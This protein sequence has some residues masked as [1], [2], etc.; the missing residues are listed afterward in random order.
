MLLAQAAVKRRPKGSTSGGGGGEGSGPCLGLIQLVSQN[1]QGAPRG[2][3]KIWKSVGSQGRLSLGSE[4]ALAVC[5]RRQLRPEVTPQGP[6]W[7]CSGGDNRS[8]RVE[9]CPSVSL[10]VPSCLPFFAPVP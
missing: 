8:Q 2:R 7:L 9:E 10:C 3:E 1:E 6:G 5:P 4:R